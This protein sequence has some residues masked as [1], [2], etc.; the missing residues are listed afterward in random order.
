[1]NAICENVQ[2]VD[3]DEARGGEEGVD[4][5][6]GASAAEREADEPG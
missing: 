2:L 6:R 1:V 3:E 5:G 4:A